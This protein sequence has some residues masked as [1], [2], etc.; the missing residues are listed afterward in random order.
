MKNIQ[1]YDLMRVISPRKHMPKEVKKAFED[2][3][4]DNSKSNG[5]YVNWHVNVE[6]EGLN[7]DEFTPTPE[8]TINRWLVSNGFVLGDRVLILYSW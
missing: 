2:Y 6:T 7:E 3:C 8:S 4:I 1:V 5:S